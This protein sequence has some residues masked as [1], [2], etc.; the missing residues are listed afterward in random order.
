MVLLKK[1]SFLGVVLSGEVGERSVNLMRAIIQNIVALSIS[2]NIHRTFVS[3]RYII[4]VDTIMVHYCLWVQ[5]H[6][7]C[8]GIYAALLRIYPL[9]IHIYDLLVHVHRI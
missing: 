2:Q 3:R 9:R 1:K 4:V 8:K 5:T 6:G 7:L